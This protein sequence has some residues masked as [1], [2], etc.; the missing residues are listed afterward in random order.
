MPQFVTGLCLT[1]VRTACLLG[2]RHK[3]AQGND[4]MSRRIKRTT[5]LLAICT[6]CTFPIWPLQGTA[7]EPLC[8]TDI[9]GN[10]SAE[11]DN[12]GLLLLRHLFGFS[13]EA[14]IDQSI[15]NGC[16]RCS[17]D[18]IA[19]YLDSAACQLLFD[20][21]ANG[22]R[23]ALTD[24][25]LVRRHLAGYAGSLLTTGAAASDAMRTDPEA[26]GNWLALGILPARDALNDTG[27]TWGGSH[28]SGN[29]A[30]CTSSGTIDAPQDC[31][32]GRDAQAA[33]GTLAKV[34][35]GHG[36]FDF[37]KLDADGSALPADAASW[38]CVRD[39]H[40][41]LVWEVKTDDDGIHDANTSYR[42]G[43][44]TALGAGYGT[45]Y[46]DWDVLVDGSNA[47]ALCGFSDWRVPTVRELEGIVSR[48]RVNPA[49]DTGYFLNTRSSYFWSSSPDAR[50]SGYAWIVYFGGGLSD[51]VSRSYF[52][53]VRLVRSGQ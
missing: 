15:G 33:A 25:L 20:A 32:Q 39:N 16:S 22:R 2:T 12:D 4:A 1:L 45:Y 13:D 3:D 5:R 21:D 43:G 46:D 28:S 53:P 6:I 31:H 34:G 38:S 48:D 35:A 37:T 11:A 47:E 30:N 19:T 49:I 8:G 7:A 10:G 29:N 14:L 36:G 23:D 50:D 40:T 17:A 51:T 52:R 44:V 9:D 41:G 27:I 26:I 18:A 24:G 42:W